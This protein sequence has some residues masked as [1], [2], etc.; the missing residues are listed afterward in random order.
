MLIKLF[1]IMAR[2]VILQPERYQTK[3]NTVIFTQGVHVEELFTSNDIVTH[4]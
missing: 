4:Y 2:G 1:E 3:I